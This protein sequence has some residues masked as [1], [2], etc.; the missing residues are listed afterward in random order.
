MPLNTDRS[1]IAHLLRRA[2][3]GASHA[4]VDYYAPMGVT[5]AV[6]AL[7]NYERT[8]EE[9]AL[10]V[11]DFRNINNGNLNPIGVSMWW[12]ARLLVTRRPLEEKLTLFWHDHFA[13]SAAKVQYGPMMYGQLVTLRQG[14]NGSFGELL[15]AVAKDPAMIFWLDTQRSTKKSPNENFA[16]EVMELFTLGVGNYS[17]QDIQEAARAFTGWALNRPRRKQIKGSDGKFKPDPVALPSIPDYQYIPLRADLGLKTVLGVSGRF[18]GEQVLD[19]LLERPETP[20]LIAAKLLKFFYHPE[21]AEEEITKYAKVLADAD[22]DIRALLE[23]LFTSEEFYSDRAERAIY[24]SPVDF[25]I[26]T[27]RALGAGEVVEFLSKSDEGK[28]RLAGVLRGL[29]QIMDKMGQKLLFP[30]DVAGWDQGEAW[31]NTATMLE[32][33]KLADVLFPEQKG[34]RI[35]RALGGR[36]GV[37]PTALWGPE[38]DD[39]A[40]Y[41]KNALE[42]LDAPLDEQKTDVIVKALEGDELEETTRARLLTK[43]IFSAP[44]YQR[45]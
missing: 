18:S 1:K 29:E 15:H 45:V 8:P 28:R 3:L 34:G 39:A 30:P 41:T 42:T 20:R 26:G 24:K 21:P 7:L 44:E 38:A 9:S 6:N 19:I 31:I 40:E 25:V 37:E 27:L 32:R 10:E 17:E 36:Q 23:A 11:W 5:G 33:V 35:G 4:E 12:I 14:A 43:L 22:L 2:G 16:R 13:T